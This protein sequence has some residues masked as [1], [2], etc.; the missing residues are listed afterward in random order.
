MGLLLF[1]IEKA[2]DSVWHDGLIFKLKKFGFPDYL[3]AM[4]REF[5]ANRS[6]RVHVSD[7]RSKPKPIP[8]GLPQGSILSLILYS[9]FVSDLKVG[10]R[11]N[12]TCLADN[13]AVYSSSNQ[14]N[15]ICR[16]LQLSLTRVENFFAK[17]K[18]KANA[19]KTQAILFPFDRRKHRTPTIQL[20]LNGTPVEFCNTVKYFGFTLDSKLLFKQH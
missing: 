11:S 7:A 8:A 12:T 10:A 16:R 17:W 9:I 1:D 15:A 19:A 6:F 18:I 4:M 14:S 5:T 13:T 20:T 3:C 2:F